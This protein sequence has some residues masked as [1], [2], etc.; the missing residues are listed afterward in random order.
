MTCR[1]RPETAKRHEALTGLAGEAHVQASTPMKTGTWIAALM[2]AATG[3]QSRPV[4]RAIHPAQDAV[5]EA[6][7][8]RWNSLSLF[9]VPQRDQVTLVAPWAAA[10][11]LA[12][13]GWWLAR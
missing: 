13:T 3:C 9:R 7:L 11:Q 6:L 2:A 4:P 1:W 10:P 12:I 5:I 8:P